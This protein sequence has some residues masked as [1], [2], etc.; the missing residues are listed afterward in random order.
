MDITQVQTGGVG[1]FES[2]IL[3]LSIIGALEF[4][5]TYTTILI[6]FIMTVAFAEMVSLQSH[7]EKEAKI[8]FKSYIIEWYFFFCFQFMVIPNTFLTLSNLQRSGLAPQP[9]S[10]IS[11]LCYEYHDLTAFMLL[12]FGIILFVVSLQ[13]GYYS[14]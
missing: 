1:V 2:V 12:T 3:G 4:G 14:Y 10:L 5:F 11:I 9:G 7:K 6:E 13:E 8:L